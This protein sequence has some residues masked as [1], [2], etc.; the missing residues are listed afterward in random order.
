MTPPDR[1]KVKEAV[2]V[3]KFYALDILLSLATAYLDGTL[4]E[5]MDEGE[6]CEILAQCY[7]TKEN[8]KKEVDA[9]LIN[10]IVK[11]LVGKVAKGK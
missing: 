10:T 5:A 3:L 7:C 8:E 9:T 4:V 1:E 2:N 11:A 6:L